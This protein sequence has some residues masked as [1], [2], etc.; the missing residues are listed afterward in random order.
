MSLPH[1]FVVL[2]YGKSPHLEACLGSLTAQTN[3]CRII[4][5]TSTPFEGLEQIADHHRARLY[6]HGPNRGIGADW[7]AALAIG[8]DGLVTLAHQDDLYSSEF[9]THVIEAHRGMPEA[10]FSFCDSGEIWADGSPRAAGRNLRIK[11]LM[12][13][14]ATIGQPMIDGTVRRRIL[15]GFGNPILCPTVTINRSMSPSFKFREDLRTNMDWLAWIELSRIAPAVR[16]PHKLISRR[17]HDSSESAHCIRDGS[18]ASEDLLVFHSMWPKPV[19]VT[20]QS[21]YRFSYSGYMS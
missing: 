13:T 15:L 14:L 3:R 6:V 4:I 17:V 9:S 5:S 1:T 21:V 8:G 11:Q 20:L 18:R 12:V 19:A 16:I 2:A 10:A 7:N